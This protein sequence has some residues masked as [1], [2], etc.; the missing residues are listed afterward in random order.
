MHRQ[1]VIVHA[2]V[3]FINQVLWPEFEELS[4]AL[5]AHLL[6]I[7]NRIIREEVYAKPGEADEIAEPARLR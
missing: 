2:P 3:S 4:E 6:E 1:T 7:T 5:S